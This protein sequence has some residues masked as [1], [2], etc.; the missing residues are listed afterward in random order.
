MLYGVPTLIPYDVVKC[1]EGY[2]LIFE[3]AET[4]SLAY[5]I[6]RDKGRLK[7]YAT[8]LGTTLKELHRTEVPEDK[9]DDIKERY[10]EWI[11]EI[12]DPADSKMAVFSNLI[13]TIPDSNTYV[14]G[15]INLNSA[16]VQNGELL[17]LDMAG[18]ARGHALFDLQSLFG[19][20]V[21]IEKKNPGYCLK[22]YG[23][24]GATCKEFW[25]IFFNVYMSDRQLEI[26]IMNNLLLK[27]YVLKE[28]V[29]MKL[30]AKNRLNQQIS[31]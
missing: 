28:S 18:S 5:L 20:L 6:S 31:R 22:N 23:L 19:S 27:Y 12:D 16:M 2:G 29:L 7:L 10:R 17:L 9:F 4:T 13:S 24:S 1:E 25:D 15:D 8:M 14:H 3:K 30:E 26:G 11:K 21:G